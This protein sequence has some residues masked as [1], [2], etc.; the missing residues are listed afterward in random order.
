MVSH[1]HTV[2]FHMHITGES[3]CVTFLAPRARSVVFV[4]CRMWSVFRSALRVLLGFVSTIASASRFSL[5]KELG[6]RRHFFFPYLVPGTWYLVVFFNR[7][8]LLLCFLRL[9][10]TSNV[11]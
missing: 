4:L 11:C 9:V 3:R 8:T 6:V 5:R 2:V 7:C 10:R 1:K